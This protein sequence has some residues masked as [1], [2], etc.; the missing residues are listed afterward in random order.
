MEEEV[1]SSGLVEVESVSSMNVSDFENDF[2]V[3]DLSKELD[4]HI[5][6]SKYKTYYKFSTYFS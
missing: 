2:A 6:V 1:T 4:Q 3:N 5:E